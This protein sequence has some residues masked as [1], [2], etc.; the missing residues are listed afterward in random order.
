MTAILRF[1]FF[2]VFV[3]PLV[4]ICLGIN[5]RNGD[6]LPKKGPAIIVANH[7]SHLDTLVLMSLFPLKRLT[8][9]R[10]VAA[11]DYFLRNKYLKWFAL[12]IIG[13][14]PLHR[15]VS[16]E[17]TNLFQGIYDALDN[18][19]ILILFPEGT[20]G[21]AEELSQL[22]NGIARII[23]HRAETPVIPIFLHG[24]GKAL[25][26]NDWVF[27]PFFC[28][29]FVGNQLEWSNDRK[30]YIQQLNDSMHALSSEGNFP[31]WD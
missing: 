24:L 12:K 9:I 3:R 2:A 6:R 29:I 1:C 27:V 26:K 28:D 16:R 19:D 22:K 30:E 31:K 21:D 11:A 14:V 8:K 17:N 13:V 5:L 25:P 23:E 18:N 7:N 10:P 15:K 20:R 4:L